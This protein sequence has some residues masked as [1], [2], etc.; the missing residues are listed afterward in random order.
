MDSKIIKYAQ[1][2]NLIIREEGLRLLN[3][4]N[5][6]KII[7]TLSKQNKVFVEAEDIR[8]IINTKQ[9][10][11]ENI[12]ED[13]TS[14]FYILDKYDITNK[15]LSQGK[16]EDFHKLF[17]DKYNT[18]SEIIKK[19]ENFK[20]KTIANAK[21]ELK[22]K[23]VDIIGMVYSKRTTKKENLLLN[24]DDPTSSVNLVIM[25]KDEQKFLK[26]KETL[27]DN[28][29][30]FKCSV[31]NKDLFIVD[32]IL[33]PDIPFVNK[34]STLKHNK[35]MAIIGDV[36]VGSK[37]FLEKEFTDFIDWLN[38]K[39][40]EDE[41]I[42]KNIK[43]LIIAGDLVDG[44]GIYPAQFDELSITDIFEQ[45]K[46]FEDFIL[47]IPK[48]IE[49]FI[50]PGNHDAVR[51]SDPQ[52]AIDIK[53]LPRLY[54]Q[55]NIHMLG[56]PSWVVIEDFKILIYHGAAMHGIYANIKDAT[57]DKPQLAIKEIIK[58]RDLMP[59]Y[60]DRQ[61]FIP[62]EKNFLTIKERPDIYIGADVHH[63]GYCK[64]KN[65]HLINA[66]CWQSTTSYQKE[67]GHIPTL[68][69]VLLFNFKDQKLCI[70]DFY[71]KEKIE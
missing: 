48:H 26:L 60:G 22:G 12:K 68:A 28:V 42:V 54:E 47:R 45:Y 1:D 14:N 24:V 38:L 59:Q 32:E 65:C 35:Y 10:H 4:Y 7:N 49:I 29:L 67:K 52:P 23:K 71:K 25:N 33:Y 41:D 5:Y 18:L 58:R 34:K 57:M 55:E 40:N 15:T 17:L 16:V 2:N 62:V 13:N 64:Y 61:T 20:F 50:T 51:L 53:F 43:Y 56:S 37:L 63:H 39:R 44:I 69:K 30:G 31:I 66:S 19:R 9:K 11:N 36:H 21:R 6:K 27:L 3:N 70:K 8:K 46:V